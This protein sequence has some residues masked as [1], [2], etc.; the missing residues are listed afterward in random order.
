VLAGI[1]ASS[2]QLH[3]ANDPGRWSIQ[4]IV[5]HLLL[6]YQATVTLFQARLEK[7]TAT[8]LR[9]GWKQSMARTLVLHLRYFPH[10]GKS[11]EFVLPRPGVNPPWSGADLSGQM[12]AELQQ[13]DV[14]LKA[15][16]DRFGKVPL[17][18]HFAFGPLCASQWRRFHAVHAAHHLKQVRRLRPE[19]KSSSTTA[20]SSD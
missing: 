15:A 12:L 20:S 4:Q 17:Q 11:P 18:A 3:P 9:A 2:T 6:S 7:G 1:D 8:H 16:E 19:T 5:E 14:I 10:G 13:M